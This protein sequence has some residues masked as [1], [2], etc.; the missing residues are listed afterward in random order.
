MPSAESFEPSFRRMVEANSPR[1]RGGRSTPRPRRRPSTADGDDQPPSR[2][3]PDG[4]RVILPTQILHQ[5]PVVIPPATIPSSE[6]CRRAS[7]IARLGPLDC[8]AASDQLRRGAARRCRIPRRA[9][10]AGGWSPPV[11]TDRRG[12]RHRV[13]YDV[14][15]ASGLATVR[16]TFGIQ[17]AIGLRTAAPRPLAD[18][19]PGASCSAER[20]STRE[21]IPRIDHRGVD[22]PRRP[23]KASSLTERCPATAP[24]SY[25]RPTSLLP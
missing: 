15:R 20:M 17:R 5:A 4:A 22:R 14:C 25:R 9:P 11:R 2:S 8:H 3:S 7:E 10:S 12:P 6:T 24:R 18:A 23:G 13:R 16:V 19:I 1:R 21:R